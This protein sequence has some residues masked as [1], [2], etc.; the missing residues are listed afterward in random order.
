[1]GAGV[2]DGDRDPARRDLENAVLVTGLIVGLVVAAWVM[3]WRPW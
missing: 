1:M 2:S 3:G